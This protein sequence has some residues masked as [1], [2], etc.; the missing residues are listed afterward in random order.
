MGKV[1]RKD[2]IKLP[3]E[4][5]FEGLKPTA[6]CIL[7]ILID[8]AKNND[9][10]AKITQKRIAETLNVSVRTI[11]SALDDLES[12]GYIVSSRSDRASYY[13]VTK[14]AQIEPK[15]PETDTKTDNFESIADYNTAFPKEIDVKNL[16]VD[17]FSEQIK[18]QM[19]FF[20]SHGKTGKGA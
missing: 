16:D 8:R 13:K 9:W 11:Q 18:R 17:E 10:T 15:K 7:A 3:M 14:K 5:F 4:I 1:A 19:N 6:A 12:M 2:W 20:R